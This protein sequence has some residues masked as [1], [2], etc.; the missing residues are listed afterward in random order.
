[1]CI[2][3]HSVGLEMYSNRQKIDC[4]APDFL[5][6]ED[7]AWLRRLMSLTGGPFQDVFRMH[8]PNRFDK[9]SCYTYELALQCLNRID[10]LQRVGGRQV[11]VLH[12]CLNSKCR[13]PMVILCA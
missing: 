11:K 2:A 10:N 1:M 4:A 6:R 5:E 12:L 3:K 13:S 9:Y 8:H 7:R